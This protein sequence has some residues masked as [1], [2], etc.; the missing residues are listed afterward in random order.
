MNQESSVV[1]CSYCNKKLFVAAINK[2]T[3]KPY[4][5][6]VAKCEWDHEIPLSRGGSKSRNNLSPSCR[7][8]NRSKSNYTPLEFLFFRIKGWNSDFYHA[9]KGLRNR[10]N[11]KND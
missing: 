6:M 10:L 7:K 9:W 5:K 4:W 3:G 2:R 1:V 11:R 8:C